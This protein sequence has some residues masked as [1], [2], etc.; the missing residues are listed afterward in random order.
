MGINICQGNKICLMYGNNTNHTQILKII[1]MNIFPYTFF[2][3][4]IAGKTFSSD[5]RKPCLITGERLSLL[6][7]NLF[8]SLEILNYILPNRMRSLHLHDLN[9]F[10]LP[11]VVIYIFIIICNIYIICGHY[12]LA[13]YF[14]LSLV[15][16]TGV[17]VLE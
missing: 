4:Q 12:L 7:K 2:G 16:S 14:S 6:T 9:D 13:I 17:S 3:V 15:S 5:L 10:T 1:K 11:K 8:C